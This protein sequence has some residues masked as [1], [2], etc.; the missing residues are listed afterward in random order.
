MREFSSHEVQSFPPALSEFG[1][2]QVPSA[3]SNL[4]KCLQPNSNDN[5]DPPAQID[6]KVFDGAVIV[7]SLPPVEASTFDEYT[8]KVFIPHLQHQL[9]QSKH[10]DVMWDTFV[11]DNLKDATTEKRGPGVRKVAG[12]MKLPKNCR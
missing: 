9:H 12:Q 5:T 8:K 3:K 4:L 10:V 2:L 7:H 1:N 6:C 11:P